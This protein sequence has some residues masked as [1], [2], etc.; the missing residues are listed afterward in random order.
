MVVAT[1]LFEEQIM[2]AKLNWGLAYSPQ[3][4][5]FVIRFTLTSPERRLTDSN[6]PSFV[7]YVQLVNKNTNIQL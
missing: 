6:P 2:V 4:E 7:R 1:G 5:S 3:G